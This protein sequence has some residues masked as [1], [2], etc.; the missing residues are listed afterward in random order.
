ML[1]FVFLFQQVF[2]ALQIQA[3]VLLVSVAFGLVVHRILSFCVQSK[4]FTFY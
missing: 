4:H 2:T 3:I 1:F